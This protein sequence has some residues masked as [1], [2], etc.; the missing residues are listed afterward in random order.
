MTELLVVGIFIGGIAIG[1]VAT[2]LIMRIWYRQKQE[3]MRRSIDE[4][5][6]QVTKLPLDMF[7]QVSGQIVAQNQQVLRHERVLTT[8]ELDKVTQTVN[9]MI[10]LVH[11]LERDR[12]QKYGQLDATLANTNQHHRELAS[13]TRQL[14]SVMYQKQACGQW[15]ARM[16]ED[17]LRLAGMQEGVNYYRQHSLSSSGSRPD[18]TFLLPKGLVVNMDVKFPLE[19]YSRYINGVSELD[20]D[21][22]LSAFINDV[23]R[24]VKTIASKEYISPEANTLDYVIMF[25]PSDLIYTVVFQESPALL[26]EALKH[27]VVLCSPSTLYAVVA[28]IRQAVDN[29]ALERSTNDILRL[30]EVF[31][32]EWN[33]Y[34]Q[35]VD[36]LGKK[37]DSLVKDYNELSNVRTQKLEKPVQAFGNLVKNIEEPKDGE[38]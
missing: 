30:M 32:I 12:E 14:H 38:R 3:I 36:N 25:I 18:Y 37:I 22:A 15:G 21:K 5:R 35:K 13:L 33:N 34:S 2:Y 8:S 10:S 19:N 6:E 31:I 27:H 16:A 29:Y 23:R 7:E 17:I 9:K 26:D 1:T 4:L 11:E 20:K 24:H 28:V